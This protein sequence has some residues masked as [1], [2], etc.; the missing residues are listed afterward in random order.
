MS[1]ILKGWRSAS[2]KHGVETLAKDGV[3]A[4]IFLEGRMMKANLCL[5]LAIVTVKC[6]FE[7][8]YKAYGLESL[9][10]DAITWVKCRCDDCEAEYQM[11]LREYFGSLE[12]YMEQHPNSPLPPALACRKCGKE[13]V[14][15]AAKCEICRLVFEIG[16]KA[17]DYEDKCPNCNFSS[18]EDM[19]RD[20]TLIGYV[21][22][23]GVFL[24]R[25]RAVSFS[26]SVAGM[27]VLIWFFGIRGR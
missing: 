22:R 21:K 3:E 10:P 5:I 27:A 26:P 2:G 17:G 15:E 12:D 1:G 24:T 13:S 19:R 9:P 23:F 20:R 7:G 11:R 25:N 8:G 18:I 16:W 4:D 14:Y 6:V